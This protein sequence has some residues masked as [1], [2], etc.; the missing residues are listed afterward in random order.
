MTPCPHISSCEI[1]VINFAGYPEC[2]LCCIYRHI[3]R[4][5]EG[6]RKK[7]KERERELEWERGEREKRDR[8]ER[9]KREWKRERKIIFIIFESNSPQK[10]KNSSKPIKT[11]FSVY[12]PAITN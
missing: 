3:A 5:R 10:R 9:E 1:N 8:E 6:E 12:K 11:I 7:K 2:R 4:E